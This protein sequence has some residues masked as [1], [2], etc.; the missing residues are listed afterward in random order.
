MKIIKPLKKLSL[1]ITILIL[2]FTFT[3]AKRFSGQSRKP[4]LLPL[5]SVHLIDR[6]GLAE[7]ISGKER[8]S[9]IQ[10]MDFLKPQPYQKVL[11]IYAR[12]SKGHVR[13]I[14]T[15]YH[16]NGNPKQLLEIFNG[17]AYG[18][19]KEW[20][21][22]GV[23]NISTKIVGGTPD[24]TPVAEKT[25][26]FD[27]VSYI[28]DEE[29]HL[30]AQI[31]Y[32]QGFLQG[33]SIYY[34]PTGQIWRKI[35]YSKNQIEGCV[36]TYKDNGELL[37]QTNYED[38][39]KQ[40]VCTRFW[41]QNHLACHEEYY[42]GKLENGQYFDKSGTLISQVTQGTGYRAIFSKDGINELEEY[43]SGI[44][45]GE[46][47]VFNHQGRIKR[48]Y[49]VKEGIKHGEE[50]EY[51]DSSSSD[52]TNLQPKLS[53]YWYE[54]KIHGHAKTWYPN[55]I[56]ESQREMS[57]NS[58]NGVAMAY[59]RDGNLMLIEEYDEDKLVRGDYF[60]KGDKTAASQV[61]QGKGLATL[62]DAEG[63]FTRKVIYINGKPDE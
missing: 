42:Q 16:P 31:P 24:I 39:I 3:S 21:P 47:K 9:Q 1:W 12:D 8:L 20:H 2:L 50:I 30:L 55:G 36:E 60:K 46:V 10:Q 33:S 37:Q 13:S 34:H 6:N 45:E 41:D 19:Y 32:S 62:F 28:W 14:V 38:G 11:R 61:I 44:L 29:G 18:N 59:Y 51:Y 17:R 43:H 35:P 49:H 7:T 53:F 63:H 26:L 40:G 5:T 56:L 15:S 27:G 25:W 48:I 57:N 23:L 52:S 22:N 58:R 54:G 4:R